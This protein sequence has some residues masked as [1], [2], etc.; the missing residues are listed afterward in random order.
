MSLSLAL[1]S[2]SLAST[3]PV[4]KV[5]VSP[6]PLAAMLDH[7]LRRSSSQDRVLGTLLGVRHEASNEIEVRSSFGVPYQAQGK[8]SI[9]I[10]MDHHKALLDLHHKVNAREVV[11]GWYAT[12]PTLNSFSALI[13]NFYGSESSPFPA[14]HLVLDPQTL[15]F[16][17]YVSTPVGTTQRADQ[18]AFVPVPTELRVHAQERPG[19]ELLTS[20][21]TSPKSSVA[22]AVAAASS[23]SSSSSVDPTDASTTIAPTTPLATLLTLLEKVSVMLDSV[24][25]YVHQVN[26]GEIKADERVAR[27]LLETVGSVPVTAAVT[28]TSSSKSS[29]SITNANVNPNANANNVTTSFED[30]FNA[31]LADV[32]MV[33]YLAN[34]VQ[35]QTEISSRL[36]LLV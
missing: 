8:G 22:V 32:L 33:S 5:V 23:S 15:A 7:H 25:S 29:A 2:T 19:I 12:H 24:L 16:A 6:L 36:N 4:S 11:V 17:S 34:V 14:V 27:A 31:H 21:L 20:N 9:T 13:H 10:D 30:E 3:R 18:V 28:T 26:L 35:T 1:P